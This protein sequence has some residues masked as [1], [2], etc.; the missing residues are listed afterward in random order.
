[1]YF[2]E[3]RKPKRGGRR[4]R[5]CLG[6]LVGFFVKLLLFVL[7]LALVAGAIL[8]A[9]PVGLF[10]IEPEAD[11][12]P[13]G[14]LP[15]SRINVLF[16]GV[17]KLS[18]GTQRSDAII[19]ATVGYD[20]FKLT[21]IMRD[22]MVD[23]PGHGQQKVNAAYAHGG[24]ELTMQTLN[25]NFGLN[26]TKYVVVDFTTL[27][28]LVNAIGG[29]DIAI[30]EA[31]Q[32][33]INKNVY[34]ARKVFKSAGYTARDTSELS[35]DF[36]KA[37]EDGCVVAHL[38]GIQ[39]LGYAR[40]RHI[41][42][43]ITRTYRQRKLLNAALKEFRSQWYNPLVLYRLSENVLS[44]LGTNMSAVEILSLGLKAA[45][46]PEAE[47][48]RLPIDGSYNDNGSALIGVDY[49][50]NREAFLEFAY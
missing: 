1:V 48:L 18:D 49:D 35:L 21:S 7:L 25:E 6:G 9:L 20:A 34:D 8:Y 5:G 26:L 50:R 11:L 46:R 19:V 10:M 39:A 16:L 4:R 28:G 31:E 22:T 43:D 3:G 40:I 47:Q 29:V 15:T 23:I 30:T 38:D 14:D 32:T 44:G 12:S 41:D 33:E 17:D 36:S 24:A 42:S 13:A 37:D 45:V 27:A 2:E